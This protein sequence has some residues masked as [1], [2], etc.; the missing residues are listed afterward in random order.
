MLTLIRT[1]GNQ[2]SQIILET[3]TQTHTRAHTH[4]HTHTQNHRK[5]TT[6]TNKQTSSKQTTTTTNK[7]KQNSNNNKTTQLHQKQQQ[8]NVRTMGNQTA[9]VPVLQLRL[10]LQRINPLKKECVLES[11]LKFYS[12]HCCQ[13]EPL[14]RSPP[15]HS[16]HILLPYP[17]RK[18]AC[19]NS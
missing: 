11:P 2:C 7:T 1:T 12:I 8:N 14:F 15:H 3:H 6:K 4:M 17:P 19:P 9:E 13:R 18:K 16:K 10:T 5:T